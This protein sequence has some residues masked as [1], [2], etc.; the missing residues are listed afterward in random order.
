[1]PG[2]EKLLEK[3]VSLLESTTSRRGFLVRFALGATAFAV[4]GVRYLVRPQSALAYISCS[5]CSSTSTCCTAGTSCFC[6]VITGSNDCPTNSA[7][8]GWWYCSTNGITYIDCCMGCAGYSFCCGAECYNSPGCKFGRE[9]FNCGCDYGSGCTC[10]DA[11][12]TIRCRITRRIASPPN[13]LTCCGGSMT[14]GACTSPPP[15]AQV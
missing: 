10:I 13:G 8:C 5:N 14:P 4:G 1:M 12:A 11:N 3:T 7:R 15:C 6:C 9:Y 2:E